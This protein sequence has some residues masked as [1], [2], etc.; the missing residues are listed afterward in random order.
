[1]FSCF[2][3]SWVT[4]LAALAVA[5]AALPARGQGVGAPLPPVDTPPAAAAQTPDPR[6]EHLVT[7]DSQVRIEEERVRGQV[8]RIVVHPKI[9][10]M[11][12]YEIAA[13]TPG[14]GADPDPRAGKRIWW[15]LNF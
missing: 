11:P 15:S 4:P 8:Q 10:G 2:R 5:A 6:I 9:P 13:P 1:M 7:E 14:R 3:A 12:A